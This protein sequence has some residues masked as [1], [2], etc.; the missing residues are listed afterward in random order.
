MDRKSLKRKHLM[1][2]GLTL[3]LVMLVS[4]LAE[5]K[6]FRIDL[7]A[8]KKH[9]LSQPSRQM[10]GQLEDVIYVK[11]YLD[12]ELPAA[13]VNIEYSRLIVRTPIS[14]LSTGIRWINASPENLEEAF[15]IRFSRVI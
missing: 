7:T 10:L 12:G 13:F 6:F 14:K 2:L 1:Q 4:L 11:V 15:V 5:V 9:T 8:E 3:V